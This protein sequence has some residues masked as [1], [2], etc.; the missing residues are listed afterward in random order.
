MSKTK[1]VKN[2]TPS[3]NEFVVDGKPTDVCWQFCSNLSNAVVF[4]YFYKYLN[5]FEHEDLISLATVDSVSF[6]LKIYHL[7]SGD[8]IKNIRN[9]FFTR[10]RNTLSNFVFRSNKLINTE[11]EILD[12][13]IVYPKSNDIKYDLISQDDLQ[14]DSIESFRSVSLKTW[15]L[16]KLNN[17][18]KT[19]YIINDETNDIEDWKA[20]SEARNMKTPCDLISIY[21]NYSDDQVEQLAMKLDAVT[22]QN[23][24]NTLYQLLGDKFLAFLDVFQEDKF[25]I[26]STSLVKHLL[27]DMS[28]CDDYSNGMTVD[29]LSNKYNK[30]DVS[31]QKI[32]NAKDIL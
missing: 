30:S 16:F 21:N 14:I 19:H 23:Y 7:N 24:F 2:T 12:H 13:H 25:N 15:K 9:V 27:T 32:I 5:Y 11:D 29:E 6:A 31:I 1:K 10:I 28:I 4:K 3:F 26:P 22:G 18:N 8:A 17:L 20:Y